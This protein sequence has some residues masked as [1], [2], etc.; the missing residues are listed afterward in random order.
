MRS[1][2][3]KSHVE[4]DLKLEIAEEKSGIRHAPTEGCQFLGYNIDAK[5]T[6]KI[7][8][9]KRDGKRFKKRTMAQHISLRVPAEK[10]RGFARKNGYGNYANKT[11]IHR[12]R[13]LSQSDVEI[14]LQVNAELR[15]FSQYYSLANNAKTELA[16]IVEV[17]HAQNIGL[18][19]QV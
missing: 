17:K 4:T 8:W 13:M 19:T 14:V 9:V 10:L 7:L 3:L 2:A 11:A 12:A 15:G 5:P 16:A 6:P 1:T 18:E